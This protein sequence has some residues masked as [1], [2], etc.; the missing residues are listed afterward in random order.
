MYL[1][2]YQII[3]INIRDTFDKNLPNKF[4]FFDLTCNLQLCLS[5]LSYI[6]K[7]LMEIISDFKLKYNYIYH[8]WYR[9]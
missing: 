1:R 4:F 8:K 9:L 7:Q 2:E 6:L 3:K 5:I